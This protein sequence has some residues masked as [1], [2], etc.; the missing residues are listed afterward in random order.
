M[1]VLQA[2]SLQSQEPPAIDF[3]RYQSAP[4]NSGKQGSERDF[5]SSSGLYGDGLS[6]WSLFQGEL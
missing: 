1:A 2:A 6:S 4:L 3:I 5:I